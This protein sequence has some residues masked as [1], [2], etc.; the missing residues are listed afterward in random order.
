[1]M[2]PCPTD[3]GSMTELTALI[4][5]GNRLP[6]PPVRDLSDV[7]RETEG[8]GG[9]QAPRW[10]PASFAM[11]TWRDAWRNMSVRCMIPHG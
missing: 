3:D 11:E 2:A 6:G 8:S 1:M 10:F 5:T 9:A 4:P 7:R